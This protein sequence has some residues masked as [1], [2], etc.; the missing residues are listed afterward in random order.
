MKTKNFTTEG[1]ES[2][3]GQGEVE[4]CCPCGHVLPV[5]EQDDLAADFDGVGA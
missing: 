3:S 1:A 4:V 2:Q 5:G